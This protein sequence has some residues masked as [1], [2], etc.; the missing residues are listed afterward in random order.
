VKRSILA[1]GNSSTKH[2]SQ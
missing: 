2:F 1:E